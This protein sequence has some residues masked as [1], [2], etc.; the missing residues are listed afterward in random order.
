MRFSREMVTQVMR[1]MHG[2][3]PLRRD[4]PAAS[5]SALHICDHTPAFCAD[6]RCVASAACLSVSPHSTPKARPE[7]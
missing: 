3:L 6:T 7:Q 1:I 2:A 4:V 5:W